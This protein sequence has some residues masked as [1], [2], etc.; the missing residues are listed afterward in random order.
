M[1]SATR[2]PVHVADRSLIQDVDPTFWMQTLGPETET[3][4]PRRHAQRLKT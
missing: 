1:K 4:L 2:D 3:C